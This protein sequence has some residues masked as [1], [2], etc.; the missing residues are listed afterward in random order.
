MQ[1]YQLDENGRFSIENYQN[2]RPF[3]SFLPGIGGPLG[4]PLWVFYVNRGQAIASFGVE[5]KDKP[6]LEFQ[7]ANRAYQ[8]TSY[9]G[10]RT[11]IRMQSGNQSRYYEPFRQ[12]SEFQKMVIGANEL[13]LLDVNQEHK[14]QTDIVYFLLPGENLAAL[15]RMV[16]VKNQSDRPIT[17]E[18][19]DGLPSVIPFGV[20]N[21]I[22]KDIGRTVEAWMEVYNLKQNIPYYH[23]RASIADT[24]EV[25]SFEAGHYLLAFQECIDG[26]K[27]LPAIVDP[28]LVFGHNTALDVPEA[29]T[30]NGLNE[31]LSKKQ[32]TCGRTPCG[33]SASQAD[34]NP[35]E[36]IRVNSLFGHVN[37][38]ENIQSQVKYLTRTTYLDNKRREANELVTNL[39]EVISCRTSSRVF[40]M[41]CRQTYLDNILRGGWPIVFG[42]EREPKVYHI[43]SRKHGDLERDYNAFSFAPEFYSQG[44]GSYRD[45]N[46]NRRE[47]VWFNPALGD[48]NIRTFMSLI[49]ADGYNPLVVQGSCFTVLPEK[50]EGLLTF[51]KDSLKLR[52]LLSRSFT[53][54]SLLKEIVDE[55]IGLRV[56]LQEFLEKVIEESEQHIEASSAEGYWTD[57]WT[58]NLDLIDSYLAVFPE[59]QQDLLFSSDNMPFYDSALIVQPRSMKYVLN[60]AQPRQ[61]GSLVEDHQ[62]ATLFATRGR[63]AGWLRTKHGTGGIYRTNLFGKLFCLALIKFA[64][65]DPWGMGIEMEA[66]RPGWDDAM[67]G[68]PGLFGA[69][70]PET[71][72]LKRLVMFLRGALQAEGS[73]ML[74]LP[75]EMMRFLRRVVKELK[76]NPF[77]V[78]GE[79]NYQ[80]WD[81]VSLARESYRAS[82]RLGLD[83]MEGETTYAYLET[84]LGLFEVK[85]DA[86]IS[87]ANEI[88]NGLPPTY[89][90]Y[91]A[92]KFDL[93]KDKQGRPQTDAQGRPTIRVRR[94][95]P[96]PL[97]LFL[98]GMVR[99]MRILDT[100]SVERLYEQVKASPLYDR[101]LKMYKINAPL[102]G[103]S[104]DIGRARAFTPGWLENESIWLHMEYKYLL[105]VLRA[106]LYER[107]FEDFKT[108]LIPFL[109]PK[110]YG[111]SP[112][113]NS[114]FLV[115]SAHPDELLHGVG[116]VARLSGASA[117][118]LSMWR[119]M[120][121]GERPFFV[122]DD[123][124][125]LTFK[126]ILPSWL[127]N[128]DNAISFK[129]LGC[130][131]II[132]HNPKRSDTF[133]PRTVI[134]SMMLHPFGGDSQEIIGAVIPAP[135]AQHIREGQIKQIDVYF[136]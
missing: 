122:S 86:G 75:M 17:M 100:A 70:M 2:T 6:I 71:Y 11:F 4:I 42:Q 117:E 19:L 44:N 49:Q 52:E 47:D 85:I 61:M 111:R 104:K 121:A 90:T 112:L 15:V 50:L 73:G 46:Q 95:T 135:F 9:L 92:D 118:F 64:T 130:T 76:R 48:F 57:H 131:T 128:Q 133:N 5:N 97:P 30:K 41:Y 27:I 102:D 35:G 10:F 40:D 83:G 106:G 31:L 74:R 124:L 123:H 37:R 80:F 13:C 45:V 77:V 8:L 26:A 127:F 99:A 88:N 51:A 36:S 101:K 28:T 91:R 115:S 18:M 16:T 79:D 1:N 56:D 68:L 93:L 136:A 59:C 21:Q 94:F 32:I 125:C 25:S 126:P 81:N 14:L 69:S 58:Y 55:S 7:P 54:G 129:F 113:E 34:L 60:D 22:L 110:V 24:T 67:N 87:R 29:F 82:I 84:I 108:A 78:S 65:L 109:D 114:S 89:F 120:M 3:A 20:N 107:F 33:F 39:T 119:L 62:K 23:L 66:G 12:G 38:L 53:P 72:A 96:Q 43:Y 132:Y 98:E 103:M 116:F 134:S 105:E 63:Q